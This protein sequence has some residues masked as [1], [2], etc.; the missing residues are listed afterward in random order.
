MA[1]INLHNYEA[2]LLD[3][4]EGNLSEEDIFAL[5]SF[6]LLH[7][8]LN[9]DFEQTL[10]QLEK[11]EIVSHFKIELKKNEDEFL[12]NHKPLLYA[13]NLLSEKEKLAFENE[14]QNNETLRK[15][16]LLFE[17]TKLVADANIFY[18]NKEELK[19]ETQIF[20]LFSRRS[21][22]IAASIALLIG[23][24]FLFISKNEVSEPRQEIT[25]NKSEQLP[26]TK[27]SM[28]ET[29]TLASKETEPV[30]AK[31][32]LTE[33]KQIALNEKVILKQDTIIIQETSQELAEVKPQL[34]DHSEQLEE[35][36]EPQEEKFQTWLAFEEDEEEKEQA[37][38]KNIKPNFW[39]RAV[40][41]AKQMN[42][43][44]FKA[45]QAEE[46]ENNNFILSFNGFIVE[47]K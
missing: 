33:K 14:M 25:Y 36:S 18:P 7:P 29:K 2:F 15:E 40:T 24:F 3:Y 26:K 46:K 6:A 39:K 41:V 11:E 21:I 22:S 35:G 16:V 47:K 28:D 34:T 42:G 17:K 10:P 32:S 19:K 31:K 9:I 45:L 37:Q 44:G 13:E 12:L 8:E 5:K 30:K 20:F 1:E 23:L 38:A 27:I 43:L 4:L